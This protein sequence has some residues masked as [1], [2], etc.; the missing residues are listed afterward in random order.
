MALTRAILKAPADLM[1][2]GG[3][4]TYMKSPHEPNLAVGDPANDHIRI[5]SSEC[6]AAVIAEGANLGLTQR[7]R[8]ELALA[9]TRINSDAIDNSAGVN[10][11]DYEVNLKIFLK[12]MVSEG[13]IKAGAERNVVL[14]SILPEVTEHVLANNRGQH[15]L[16]TL[17][18]IRS[19]TNSRLFANL[20]SDFLAEGYG[21]IR[22]EQL[23][24]PGELDEW[25]RAGTPMPRPVIAIVQAYVKMKLY[26][27]ILASTLPDQPE[28]EPYYLSYFP[29]PIRDQ[30]GQYL[31]HHRLKR[32]ITATII[33]NKIVN[34]AGSA[35]FFKL[36]Q[37]SG[38]PT[39]K[40]ALVYLAMERVLGADAIRDA[41]WSS[42]RVIASDKQQMLLSIED[43]LQELIAD[44]LTLSY[45][46]PTFD[47]IRDFEPVLAQL[48]TQLPTLDSEYAELA[49]TAQSKGM[50]AETAKG[51]AAL[52]RCRI[53][54][55]VVVLNRKNVI[56]LGDAVKLIILVDSYLGLEW[57]KAKVKGLEVA[58]QWEL[59]HQEILFQ[60][61][62]KRRF[63]TVN[64]LADTIGKT[65]HFDMDPTNIEALV[66]LRF[67]A[68]LASFFK[69]LSAL[70]GG[71]PI[72][73]TTLTVAIN[74]LTVL[75]H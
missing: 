67:G 74:R 47:L 8:I 25:G 7:A 66:D 42:N 37:S 2:F 6:R 16:I 18:A 64:D 58:S 69:T 34:Q 71:N 13:R 10:M 62:Q 29:V 24:D 44:I 55:E 68:T 27:A 12:Q 36:E 4:G 23:P 9:G 14:M 48:L 33:T 3:I 39:D 21:N 60:S 38:Q 32:E 51:F 30:F 19:K 72:N 17:D 75:G 73:L 70:K 56:G 26:D 57:L 20:I 15:Q 63:A 28:A 49:K 22:N 50:S 5:E 31:P 43:T 1:W 52:S 61:I 11:S 41:I 59:A 65:P 35:F 40:V 45:F 53:L 54:T 46:S